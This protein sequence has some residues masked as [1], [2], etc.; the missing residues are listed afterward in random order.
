MATSID[1]TPATVPISVTSGNSI[2]FTTTITIDDVVV[3]LTPVGNVATLTIEATTTGSNLLVIS[4]DGVGPQITLNASGVVSI[5]ITAAQTTA[6]AV[7]S[8]FYALKWTRSTGAVRTLHSG[9]FTV[10]NPNS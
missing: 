2:E 3:D 7:G 1:I 4:S 8:H 9:T 10:L 5:S 6:L